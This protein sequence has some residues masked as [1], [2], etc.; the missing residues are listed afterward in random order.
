MMGEIDSF[1][2]DGNVDTQKYQSLVKIVEDF[3]R[4]KSFAPEIEEN[5]DL[6]SMLRALPSLTSSLKSEPVQI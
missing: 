1:D 2:E 4:F 3:F 5:K 6:Q